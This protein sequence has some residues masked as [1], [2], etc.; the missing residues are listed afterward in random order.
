MAI[1]VVLADDH[2]ILRE[3]VKLILARS[4]IEVVGEADNGV[5]LIDLARKLRPQVVIADMSMPLMNGIEAATEILRELDIPTILLTMHSDLQYV[6][7][8]MSS[9]ISGYLL[10]SRVSN[11]LVEAIR[12][13]SAGNVY[14]GPGISKAV[15]TGMLNKTDGDEP[16][17]ARERQVLQLIAEGYTTK[18]VA[19]VMGITPRTGESH[20]A[21]I[22]DKLNIHNA[23]GLVRYA[24]KRGLTEL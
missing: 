7:R 17:T 12:E 5:E 14:L 21:N 11:C 16:L 1:R 19:H 9:G 20:R 6:N 23:A 3:G 2:A 18:E 8:A 10:K 4:G 22:M 15:L 13:V 24:L